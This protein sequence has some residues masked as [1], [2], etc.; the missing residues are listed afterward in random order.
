[1]P[2]RFGRLAVLA[3]LAVQA[4]A[5]QDLTALL[6]NNANLTK[7]YDLIQGYADVTSPFASIQHLSVLAPNNDAFDK[8]AFSG[9]GPAFAANDT[10]TIR[11]VI[12]YH[13][14]NGTLQ[15]SKITST[16]MFLPTYLT[17]VSYTNTTGGQTVQAVKQAGNDIIFV[18]GLGSR[19]TL[20]QADLAF[21]GGTVQIVDTF[22]IPPQDFMNTTRQFNLTGTGGAAAQA[23]I[24]NTLDTE[25]DIT[26]FAPNNEAWQRVGSGV[27]GLS[28]SQL[29]N[30][31][32]YHVVNGS[33]KFS[34]SLTNNTV[35]QSST[36]QNL[37]IFS[38]GNSI[39]VNSAQILQQDILISNGVMHVIDNVLDNNAT[40]VLPNPSLT[41]QPPV[42][43]GTS[44]A[45]TP[46]TSA[47]PTTVSSSPSG[48][49]PSSTDAGSAST[50]TDG[51]AASSTTDGGP[52]S[53]SHKAAAATLGSDSGMV[54]AIFGGAALV[55]AA[56]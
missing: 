4:F 41:S 52:T 39:F 14:L 30:L 21:Q 38:G 10:D 31:L 22:L 36:G 46:F 43:P 23:G 11:S 44:V 26:I 2:L 34:P 55:A 35:L 47:F 16:P 1:M 51:S 32:G 28:V 48:S 6:A 37:T 18:S 56:L 19:S 53:T 29:T 54:A 5:L 33:V 8:I 13:I 24:N 9:L 45:D 7:F 40:S 25:T 12:E 42:V 20:V 49:S 27:E 15:S 17:N 50:T 3:V